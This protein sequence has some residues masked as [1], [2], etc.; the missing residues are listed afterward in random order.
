[1]GDIVG[2]SGVGESTLI[3]QLIK[4]PSVLTSGIRADDNKGRHTTTNRQAYQ[5][6]T[7]WRCFT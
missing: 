6:I 1:M 4:E 3:N 2:S 5:T 7:H